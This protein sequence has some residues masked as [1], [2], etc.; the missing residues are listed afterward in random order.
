MEHHIA[1]EIEPNDATARK[2]V[3]KKA[4]EFPGAA[5]GIK[6]AFISTQLKLLEDTL[7]PLELR[8]GEAM[9]F[10]GVPFAGV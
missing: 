10:G 5:T 4:R 9:I 3:E 6:H 2:I 8:R 1:R 7:P